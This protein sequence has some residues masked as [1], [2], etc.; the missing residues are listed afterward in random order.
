MKSLSC[1]E[2]DEVYTIMKIFC[3]KIWI[4]NNSWW[5]KKSTSILGKCSYVEGWLTNLKKEKKR[6][7][8]DDDNGGC[9]S[10]VHAAAAT[11][12]LLLPVLLKMHTFSKIH[13]V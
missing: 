4:L 9:T 10:C 12:L 13:N 11:S 2:M 7:K 3:S 6:K 1:Y 5:T 8:E